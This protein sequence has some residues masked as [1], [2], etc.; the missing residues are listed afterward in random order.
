[1][2]TC[3]L[4]LSNVPAYLF[5]NFGATNSFISISFTASS[6]FA[7]VKMNNELEADF[8]LLEMKDFDVILGMDLLRLNHLTIRSAVDDINV[9]RDFANV[10][11]GIPQDRQVEF[12]ID[13]VF[14]VASV[15]KA[16][17]RMIL[18]K[19]Q[20]L[21][22]QLLEKGFIRPSAFSWGILVIFVKTNDGR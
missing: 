13:L 19:L 21:K 5:L 3:I 16:P 6:N 14:G 2:K 17:Y 9:V 4:L 12:T 22:L 10:F 7:C 11:P 15:S 18:Q 8:Y 1:M 20:E